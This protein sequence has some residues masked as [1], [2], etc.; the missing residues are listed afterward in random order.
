VDVELL[1]EHTVDD[2]IANG[3]D[4]AVLLLDETTVHLT[5]VSVALIAHVGAGGI[6]QPLV[7]RELVVK[8]HYLG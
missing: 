3:N 4:E 5:E 7:H 1:L 2:L 6:G 8:S